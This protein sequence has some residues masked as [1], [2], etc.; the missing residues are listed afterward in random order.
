MEIVDPSFLPIE[1]LADIFKL[2]AGM[3]VVLNVSEHELRQGPLKGLITKDQGPFSTITSL[4]AVAGQIQILK[5]RLSQ[6]AISS[7]SDD[8]HL[9]VM[10]G[11]SSF[12]DSLVEIKECSSNADAAQLKVIFL[13]PIR[14]R[15]EFINLVTQKY[16]PALCV[17][18]HYCAIMHFSERSCWFIRGWAD[19]VMGAISKHLEDVDPC[20]IAW[21]KH[22]LSQPGVEF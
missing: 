8:R 1:G 19:A 20:L 6:G 9:V 22:V 7:V 3:S 2:I 14:L 17:L 18:A 10:D 13:W 16:P 11:I 5:D 12:T 4:E 15:S 21:P